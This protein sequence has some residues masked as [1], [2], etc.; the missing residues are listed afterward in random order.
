[1]FWLDHP[2]AAR[3]VRLSA[4]ELVSRIPCALSLLLEPPERDLALLRAYLM[5]L[6]TPPQ[7]SS[8]PAPAGAG[9]GLEVGGALYLVLVHHVSSFLYEHLERSGSP[10]AAHA[11][12][13]DDKRAFQR[14]ALRYLLDAAEPRPCPEVRPVFIM[15]EAFRASWLLYSSTNVHVRVHIR[16]V[17]SSGFQ[18]GVLVSFVTL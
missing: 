1:M 12:E 8:R 9:V 4:A 3:L 15:N 7:R 18:P 14:D 6:C 10:P 13:L 17:Y 16:V 2:D 5:R 11:A